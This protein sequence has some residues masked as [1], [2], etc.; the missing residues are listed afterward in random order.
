MSKTLS[1]SQLDHVIR[2]AECLVDRNNTIKKVDDGN[3]LIFQ[4]A[5]E[6][7]CFHTLK[8]QSRWHRW[9][10]GLS[11]SKSAPATL[12]A[13]YH[14]YNVAREYITI[15]ATFTFSVSGATWK[16]RILQ[17]LSVDDNGCFVY[18]NNT[19]FDKSDPIN[20][21]YDNCDNTAEFCRHLVIEHL[22]GNFTINGTVIK[23]MP[24]LHVSDAEADL[25]RLITLKNETIKA[26]N[27]VNISLSVTK[28]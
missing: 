7:G 17:P 4:E 13:Q 12:S 1:L 5:N 24:A 2:I 27:A 8:N 14:I 15:S 3:A 10:A 25:G 21:A 16:A 18:A 20:L 19:V 6:Y 9:L 28:G 23:D 22:N 26:L 11:D